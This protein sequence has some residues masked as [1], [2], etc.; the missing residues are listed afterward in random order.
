MFDGYVYE[1]DALEVGMVS[2]ILG[3]GRTKVDDVI[4]PKAGIVLRKKVGDKVESGEQLAV[5]YTDRDDVIKTA[6][7]RLAKAFK[8]SH[9]K[10]EPLKLVKTIIDDNGVRNWE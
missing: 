5:F 1:I 9:Q 2:L 10:P 6:K 7:E 4:D 8:I 3:A